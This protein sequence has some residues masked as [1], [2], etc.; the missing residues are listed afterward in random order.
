MFVR[1][2]EANFSSQRCDAS[3]SACS[4]NKG[5]LTLNSLLFSTIQ[6]GKPAVT[7]HRKLGVVVLEED[8]K[9]KGTMRARGH[10]FQ[11]LTALLL[12]PAIL[13]NRMQWKCIGMNQ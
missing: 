12:L 13:V 4:R 11:P 5:K 6:R 10:M 3:N 9:S 2:R 7:L 1:L 8:A